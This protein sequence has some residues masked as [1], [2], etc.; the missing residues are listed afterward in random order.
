ML[1]KHALNET[2][3]DKPIYKEN[4][5]IITSNEGCIVCSGTF[6]ELKQTNADFFN[7]YDNCIIDIRRHD[8][9]YNNN[10]KL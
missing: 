7:Y 1:V 2:M 5:Y 6:S 10:D 9:A 4:Q 8:L 3:L